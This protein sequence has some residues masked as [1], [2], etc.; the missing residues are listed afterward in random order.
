MQLKRYT[1]KELIE[2]GKDIFYKYMSSSKTFY[3]MGET[4]ECTSELPTPADFLHSKHEEMV[5][6]NEIRIQMYSDLLKS[7]KNLKAKEIEAFKKDISFFKAE[8]VLFS[9]NNMKTQKKRYKETGKIDYT[10]SSVRIPLDKK[11]NSFY[12]D[13]YL[14]VL[15]YDD[16]CTLNGKYEQYKELKTTEERL[17]FIKENTEVTRMSLCYI[18]DLRLL[19]LIS[20]LGE[21]K[22]D[23][24]CALGVSTFN[25]KF[26]DFS[27]LKLSDL[28]DIQNN[29]LRQFLQSKID[30]DKEPL[31]LLSSVYIRGNNYKIFKDTKNYRLNYKNE[32]VYTHYIR[33]VCS[34][35]GRINYNELVPD[36]LQISTYFNKNDYSS[37]AKAWWNI[38]HIGASVEGERVIDC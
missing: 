25:S 19:A 34:S 3:F 1:T 21:F 35:T 36:F 9:Y 12:D 2:I 16:V 26:S 13:F 27:N 24:V 33:Y 29:D 18:R 30:M 23:T 7:E 22:E 28:N 32:K 10:Q 38:T 20:I 11:I 6:D 17:K 4:I 31:E 15:F 8:N 5:E 14:E 37:Y